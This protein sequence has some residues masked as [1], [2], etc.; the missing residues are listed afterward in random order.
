MT[1]ASA[2]GKVILFGE[3]A[4]VYGR[5]AIAVP[6]SQVRVEAAVDP[7][8]EA[9]DVLLETPDLG[10]RYWLAEADSID[11]IAHLV[12]LALKELGAPARDL[13]ISVRSA[14]PIGRGMGSGAAVSTAIV[15]ALCRHFGAHWPPEKVSALVFEAEKLY[16]GTP[17]GI[18]NTVI[19]YEAPVYF[20]K[21]QPP[22]IIAIGAPLP[23]II[24][25][26]GIFSSTREVVGAVREA[27]GREP[28]RYEALFDAI[29]KLVNAA[30]RHIEDGNLPALGRLMDENH[31][32]LQELGVSC[33]ALDQLVEIARQAGA[34]GAKLSGA[35][36][37][38]NIIALVT[39]ERAASVESALRS[40]GAASTIFTTVT[41]HPRG[42]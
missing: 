29:G 6:V 21:G 13:R 18:D 24:A 3:H 33:P 32:L 12:R 16:H 20:V 9:G 41:S 34:L 38:G 17:S 15:R 11:G 40:A 30:R 27:R 31:R 10:R 28:A 14:L 22:Q 2:C 36:R 5:P 39:P 37:G 19:A 25:D 23:L 42:E 8:P 26:T 4:V 7:L 35:G 1:T